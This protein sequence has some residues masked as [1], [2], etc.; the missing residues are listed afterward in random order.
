MI[1][2]SKL[3]LGLLTRAP[4]AHGAVDIRGMGKVGGNILAKH[5]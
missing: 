3:T 1:A 2:D 4:I 5:P